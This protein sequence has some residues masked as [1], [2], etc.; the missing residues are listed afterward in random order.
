MIAA[1][2]P[3]AAGYEE[4]RDK[5]RAL[6]AVDARPEEI[7]WG[8]AMADLFAG[9][10]PPPTNS[11]EIVV[12]RSF[13]DTARKAA[14]HSDAN[15]FALLYRV[16]W[17]LQANRALMEDAADPDVAQLLALAKAVRRDEHKMHAFVRFKG[18][19]TDAGAHY[20]A[21][22]EPQHHILRE[23]ADFFVRRFGG[24]NWSILTPEASA[25]W[26]GAALSFGPGGQRAD[27]PAEDARDEDWRAYYAAMFNPARLRTTAMRREMPKHYWRNLP[28]AETI[29]SLVKAAA[30]RAE[31][32]VSASPSTPRKRAGAA[33]RQIAPEDLPE[34]LAPVAEHEAAPK[35]MK[36]LQHALS[37]CRACPLWKDATQAVPGEGPSAQPL[38]AF[39]G[40][41]PGDQEDLAG[42]PFVGPAGKV[43]NRALAEAGIDRETVF[44]TN[45]VKH[46]KHEQRGK[47][48]LHK[49]PN[50]G[51]VEI[52]RWWVGHEL[53]LVQPRLVVALGATALQSL[54][55]YHGTMD[56]ARGQALTTR[57]GAALRATIHP[58]YLLRLQDDDEK[59]AQYARF[60][61]DLRYAKAAARLQEAA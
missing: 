22:F 50:K 20:V 47:R 57:E 44:V 9:A 39:V 13:V 24:M 53:A 51:E 38:L 17:R 1:E 18:I 14:L 10:T 52:C 40:E 33:H 55:D 59:E 29:P 45:A 54:A 27:V 28:E 12:S 60:V 58:S 2:L 42:H 19:E 36:E 7:A 5:A 15:R 43:L 35:S 34:R 30:A 32:M 31:T 11:A 46:F 41:Q 6:L 61:E 48:R 23:T 16:L 4:W 25:H 56:A 8:G 3:P 21:W 26:N 37:A 49:R